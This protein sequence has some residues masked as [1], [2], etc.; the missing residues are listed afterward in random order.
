MN[1]LSPK[2]MTTDTPSRTVHNRFSYSRKPVNEFNPE[3]EFL[4][5]Q[6]LQTKAAEQSLQEK[7]QGGFRL[8]SF[9]K[10][11]LLG[12]AVTPLGRLI[13]NMDDIYAKAHPLDPTIVPNSPN[14]ASSYAPVEHDSYCPVPIWFKKTDADQNGG[15]PTSDSTPLPEHDQEAAEPTITPASRYSSVEQD[16]YCPLSIWFENTEVNQ[17]LGQPT[18]VP[19]DPPPLP[20]H[21]QDATKSPLNGIA[22]NKNNNLMEEWCNGKLVATY[23]EQDNNQW[24]IQY[25]D[26]EDEDTRSSYIGTINDVRQPDGFGTMTFS[27]KR[28]YTGEFKDG[29]PDGRGTMINADGTL[30]EGMWKSGNLSNG[31]KKD[32]DNNPMEGWFD[33]TVIATYQKQDNNQWEIQYL[34]ESDEQSVYTGTINDRYEPDGEG[35]MTFPDKRTFKGNF[36]DGLPSRDGTMSFPD[37]RTYTGEYQGTQPHGEGKMTFPD[38]GTYTGEFKN[39]QPDGIGTMIN[40]DGTLLEGIW[41]SGNLIY[42]IKKDRDNNS[43]EKWW[44]DTLIATYQKQ[45]NNQWEIQYLDGGYNQSVYIGTINNKHQP[46]GEGTMTFRDK[47]T[48]KGN[49]QDGKPDGDGIISNPDGTSHVGRWRWVS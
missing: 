41:Q 28:T 27:D 12:V 4:R 11:L 29:Q 26:E 24:E 16:I 2:L 6:V 21:D 25:L 23:Q 44:G 42:T 15:Q 40:A 22:K 47:R 20:E 9:F 30:L 48:F 13:K 31:I 49:F 8:R 46:D 14:P 43:M 3:I 45:D 38:K 1:P 34:G 33:G 37:K 5:K 32:R 17:N 19:S 10:V 39:G 7:T 35:T 18:V 36:K